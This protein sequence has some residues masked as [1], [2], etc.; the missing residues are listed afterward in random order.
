MLRIT[1]HEHES[2]RRLQLEG[3]LAGPW[4][5][6]AENAWQSAHVCG[7]SLVADLSGVTGIDEPG[8]RLLRS[9][10]GAGA[11]FIATGVEM[12]ALLRE[13]TK[14]R[15]PKRPPSIIRQVKNRRK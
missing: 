13:I 8:L 9:M 3:R 6:E 5:M 15:T 2:P 12:K 14:A 11:N 1:I 10:H 7:E 4:V